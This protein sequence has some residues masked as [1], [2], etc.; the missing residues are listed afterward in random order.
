MANL[1]MEQ[2]QVIGIW[3]KTHGKQSLPNSDTLEMV[4][5]TAFPQLFVSET[6]KNENKQ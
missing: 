2:A 1:T 5:Q 4:H 6:V 3:V